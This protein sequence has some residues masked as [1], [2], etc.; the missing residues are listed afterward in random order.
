M[1]TEGAIASTVTTRSPVGLGPL[2]LRP[3]RDSYVYVPRH[4]RP[5]QPL[6]LVLL[7]HG[8]GGHAHHGV[9]LL[10]HLADEA[11]LI[12]VAPAST[13]HSWDAIIGA[14]GPDVEMLDRLE[15]CQVLDFV[16]SSDHAPVCATFSV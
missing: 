14:Y 2:A 12:L 15:R 16:P 9:D 1:K 5:E 7:L 6:P 10:R 4:Y 8:S 3:E 11:G 13:G